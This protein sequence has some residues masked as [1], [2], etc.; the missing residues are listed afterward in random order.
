MSALKAAAV[1]RLQKTLS[2]GIKDV[3]ECTVR[4]RTRFDDWKNVKAGTEV[5]FDLCPIGGPWI[6]ARRQAPPQSSSPV[7]VFPL[8]STDASEYS[9]PSAWASWHESWQSEGQKVFRLSSAGWTLFW[10]F[11]QDENKTQIARAEWRRI[12]ED[13]GN[14]HPQ[15]HWHFDQ[16]VPC[17]ENDEPQNQRCLRMHRFHFAM[18][19]WSESRY[20]FCWQRTRLD[21]LP[22]WGIK[23]LRLIQ[24]QSKTI[25]VIRCNS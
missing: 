3:L 17:R 23:T 16:Q 8:C 10:G 11:N 6:G 24:D 5:L 14:E 9:R 18:G 12:D 22:D 25:S 19:A 20:P 4:H 15:P 2:D 21:D 7:V 13:E 1:E